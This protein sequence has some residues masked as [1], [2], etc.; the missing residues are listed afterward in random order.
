M[1][2]SLSKNRSL[3]ILNISSNEL[4]DSCTPYLEEM[5]Y[6]NYSL[7]ELY[8]RWN[9][10]THFGGFNIL[11]GLERKENLAVLDLSWNNLGKRSK[12]SEQRINAECPKVGRFVKKLC[13]LL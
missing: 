8:L 4:S 12:F 3:K 9:K 2:N 5:L 6:T 1:C 7:R 13:E 11:L 10:V